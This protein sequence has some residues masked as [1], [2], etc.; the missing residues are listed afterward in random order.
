MYQG[1]LLIGQPTVSFDASSDG[2]QI[3]VALNPQR[4]LHVSVLNAVGGSGAGPG[5]EVVALDGAGVERRRQTSDAQGFATLPLFPTPPLA[6]GP[7]SPFKYKIEIYLAGELVG[8]VYD[9]DVL[10]SSLVYNHV[11]VKLTDACPSGYSLRPLPS[12]PTTNLSGRE[13]I[14][15]HGFVFFQHD[16]SETSTFDPMAYFDATGPNQQWAAIISA[17]QAQGTR[18]WT[19]QWPTFGSIKTAGDNLRQDILTQFHGGEDIVLVGHS[20]GGLVS[21]QA[22]SAGAGLRGGTPNAPTVVGIVTL[23]TPHNGTILATEASPVPLVGGGLATDETDVSA[24]GHAARFLAAYLRPQITQADRARTR[25]LRGA[26]ANSQQCDATYLAALKPLLGGHIAWEL[27]GDCVT[28]LASAYFG[29]PTASQ[30][31]PPSLT[32]NYFDGY[33]HSQMA[34]NYSTGFPPIPTDLTIAVHNV[35]FKDFAP[36]VTLS[37]AN[38]SLGASGPNSATVSVSNTGAGTLR[39]IYATTTYGSGQ[40]TNWLVAQLSAVTG[41]PTLS[42]QASPQGLAPGTYTATLGVGALAT[43]NGEQPILVTYTV[44]PL[45]PPF[46]KVVSFASSSSTIQLGQSVD[47]TLTATNTGQGPA[48]TGGFMSIAFPTLRSASSASE[49]TFVSA[50]NGVVPQQ[51]PTGATITGPGGQMPATYLL[52]EFSRPSWPA[53]EVNTMTQRWKPTLTG[54]FV[55]EA[56]VALE[57]GANVYSRDPVTGSPPLDQQGYAVVRT[58]VTVNPPPAT[59]LHVYLEPTGAVSGMPFTTQPVIELWDAAGH[60]VAQSG[61]VV[62]AVKASGPGALGGTQTATTNAQGQATFAT[63]QLTGPGTY[64]L[65]FTEPTLTKATS[66]PFMVTSVPPTYLAVVTQPTG[67]VSGSR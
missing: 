65:D 13:V 58:T 7:G 3:K 24:T 55:V 49:V 34:V 46:A 48:S 54:N 1:G 6:L 62:T 10:S 51:Y 67:G 57:I 33:D 59:A 30:V 45:P 23:G 60:P 47:F 14:L 8:F 22:A 18:V 64:T 36:T 12:N 15:V 66:Q 61:V 50:T 19:Y 27:P 26:A 20:F 37:S 11:D 4:D 41:A 53:A 43:S 44:S 29:Y 56:R 52:T 28:S 32:A 9:V 35:L 42:L 63:L 2:S 25:V 21:V 16:C 31:N 17:L 38:V 39:G 40:P 5:Y